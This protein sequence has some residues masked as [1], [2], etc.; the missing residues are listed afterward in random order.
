MYYSSTYLKVYRMRLWISINVVSVYKDKNKGRKEKE[1]IINKIFFCFTLSPRN[2]SPPIP[3]K[4]N[5]IYIR[6]KNPWIFFNKLLFFFTI[7]LVFLS[8]SSY[9]FVSLGLTILLWNGFIFT[10]LIEFMLCVYFK[11]I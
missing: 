2:P 6:I 5:I 9:Y 11:C 3:K 8:F 4:K 10:L 1:N 7:F